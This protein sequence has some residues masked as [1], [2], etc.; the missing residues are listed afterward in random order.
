MARKDRCIP[1]VALKITDYDVGYMEQHH[2]R[3]Y[4]TFLSMRQHIGKEYSIRA[5]KEIINNKTYYLSYNLI[6]NLAVGSPGEDLLK[7]HGMSDESIQEMRNALNSEDFKYFRLS[8]NPRANYDSAFFA[9]IS[10]T[11]ATLMA[12]RYG[13][14]VAGATE[15]DCV[16]PQPLTDVE[17]AVWNIYFAFE[18]IILVDDGTGQIQLTL[19]QVK[20]D[21]LIWNVENDTNYWFP[22][23][24]AGDTQRAKDAVTVLRT[25]DETLFLANETITEQDQFTFL[26]NIK[27]IAKLSKDEFEVISQDNFFDIYAPS[28][29]IDYKVDQSW[30]E[31]F[32]GGLLKFIGKL[33]NFV[34]DVLFNIPIVGKIIEWVVEGI[35]SLFGLTLEEARAALIQAI[36]FIVALYL[37]YPTG[38]ASLYAYVEWMSTAWSIGSIAGQA[39]ALTYESPVGTIEEDE[40]EK[41]KRELEKMQSEINVL[42]GIAEPIIR[43]NRPEEEL[44]V[45]GGYNVGYSPFKLD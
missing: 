10:D 16:Q 36:V 12:R 17:Q 19:D 32:I 11:L 26:I 1:P 18:L 28:L 43:L 41:L 24:P 35:A 44:Q 29:F 31:R 30:W 4:K 21:D 14:W 33:L 9:S 2:K 25:S 8:W 42:A 34:L 45:N 39:A 27:R 37:S 15:L 6:G 3:L 13:S 20:L 38:G 7:W 23:V 40:Q 5:T 22:F